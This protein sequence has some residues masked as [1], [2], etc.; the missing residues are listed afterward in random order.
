VQEVDTAEHAY[1]ACSTSGESKMDEAKKQ[2]QL[3][4]NAA[5]PGKTRQWNAQ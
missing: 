2:I 5:E 1:P 3:R 4:D